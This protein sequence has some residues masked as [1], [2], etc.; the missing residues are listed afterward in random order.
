MSQKSQFASMTPY[1]EAQGIRFLLHWSRTG[2]CFEKMKWC[3][4]AMLPILPAQCDRSHFKSQD[5]V[6]VNVHGNDIV[7]ETVRMLSSF[8]TAN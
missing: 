7:P 1:L 8:G 6:V 5:T 3:M 2:H 4:H